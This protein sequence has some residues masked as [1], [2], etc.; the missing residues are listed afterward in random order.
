MVDLEMG[1]FQR[2]NTPIT[3]TSQNKLFGSGPLPYPGGPSRCDNSPCFVIAAI[4][5]WG[6]GP[7]RPGHLE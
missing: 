4:A 7:G 1:A 3:P 5:Q 6:Q 2:C